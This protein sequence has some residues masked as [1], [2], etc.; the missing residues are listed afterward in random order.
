MIANWLADDVV[1]TV[2]LFEM[3]NDTGGFN[4]H[5]SGVLILYDT[6]FF[7]ATCR[8]IVSNPQG[9]PHRGLQA[10]VNKADGTIS[11]KDLDTLIATLGVSWFFHQDANVDLAL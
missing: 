8:H 5:G 3:R 10:S 1:K 2:V 4:P 9:V 7:L 11:R 6:V